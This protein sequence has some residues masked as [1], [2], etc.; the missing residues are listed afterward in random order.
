MKYRNFATG[1]VI[2]LILSF[3]LIKMRSQFTGGARTP[4]LI[5]L[6]DQA[7]RPGEPWKVNVQLAPDAAWNGKHESVVEV[8]ELPEHKSVKQYLTRDLSR[9]LLEMPGL[10]AGKK[11]R[12]LTQFW[13]CKK[14]QPDVCRIQGVAADV[15]PDD[16]AAKGLVVNLFAGDRPAVK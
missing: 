15:N 5:K 14:D 7:V 13:F 10:E 6:S 16:R 11:Y 2:G 1:L 4:E 3:V 9:G 8:F 12:L